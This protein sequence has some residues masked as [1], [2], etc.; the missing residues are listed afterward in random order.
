MTDQHR[1]RDLG[2]KRHKPQ[3]DDGQRTRKTFYDSSRWEQTRLAKL[4]RD[5]LCQACAA[6]G[7][8]VQAE[9]VDHW[10]SLATGGAATDDANLVSLCASDHSRK[11]L[12]ERAGLPPPFEIVASAE[13]R[14]VIA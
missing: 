4:R 14:Y 7:L 9:H 6:R 11:T 3:R 10:Q 5:P 12:A 1:P 8:A 2:F 13:R